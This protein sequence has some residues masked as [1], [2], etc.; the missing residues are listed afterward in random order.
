MASALID[1]YPLPMGVAAGRVSATG[2]GH[3][4]SPV[5]PAATSI[6]KRRKRHLA[7]AHLYGSRL[8]PDMP[9]TRML[10]CKSSPAQMVYIDDMDQRSKMYDP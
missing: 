3:L 1:W 9:D 6:S 10:L 4:S 7:A 5:Q 8:V 2:D